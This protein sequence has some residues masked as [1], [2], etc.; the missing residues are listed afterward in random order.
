MI[1]RPFTPSIWPEKDLVSDFF[2][3]TSINLSGIEK[4]EPEN[5]GLDFRAVEFLRI[6]NSLQK[7]RKLGNITRPR[8]RKLAVNFS[9]QF[10]RNGDLHKMRLS[11]EQTDILREHFRED[12][13]IALSSS[14][15]DP[16]QF[17]PAPPAGQQSLIAPPRLSQDALMKFIFSSNIS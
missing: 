14:G 5:E 8:A 3:A 2:E 12:N 7:N 15:V 11:S 13:A 6:L 9:N 1:V 16:D 4:V 10:S 17:F